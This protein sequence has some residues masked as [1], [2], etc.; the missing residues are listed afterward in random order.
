MAPQFLDRFTLKV[1]IKVDDNDI[2]TIIII[3]M[4]VHVTLHCC[5]DIN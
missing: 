4:H 3:S 2:A 1:H 5:V